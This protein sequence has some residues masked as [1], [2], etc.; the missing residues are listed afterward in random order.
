MCS[1]PPCGDSAIV[2]VLGYLHIFCGAVL[3]LQILQ[4]ERESNAIWYALFRL[5]PNIHSGTLQLRPHLPR[6]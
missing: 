1:R 2:A 5:S 4:Y 3:L 6:S